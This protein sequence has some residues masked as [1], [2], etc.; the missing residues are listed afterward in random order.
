M[1]PV[2]IASIE[3][4]LSE[5]P[6]AKALA[7][8]LLA[9]TQAMGLLPPHTPHRVDLDWDLLKAIATVLEENR[10]A[11]DWSS[12]LRR[13][14][15]ESV[16]DAAMA[17]ALRA[18]LDSLNASPHPAGEW[19]PVRETL[20]DDL[21]VR[22]LG[23]SESS[24]RRYAAGER[25]TP[26]AV[27]WRLH[28]VARIIGSLVGS[29]NDFG[30]RRWFERSRAALD[31]ATPSEIIAAADNEDDGRLEKTIQLADELLGAGSAT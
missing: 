12:H 1:V 11:A 17:E 2:L 31:G 13:I 7:M 3:R 24:L 28:A 14:D 9:R 15:P 21:T 8:V 30:V 10:L 6:R 27:A 16:D 22:L 25:E 20:G 4:P 29:Y 19:A 5:L 26:D 18:I 23:I